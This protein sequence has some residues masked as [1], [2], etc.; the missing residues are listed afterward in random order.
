MRFTHAT[1]KILIHS[2][3]LRQWKFSKLNSLGLHHSHSLTF[4][5]LCSQEPETQQYTDTTAYFFMT[6]NRVRLF[7]MPM[8]LSRVGNTSGYSSIAPGSWGT[9]AVNA[10]YTLITLG[11]AGTVFGTNP[12]CLQG[13]PNKLISNHSHPCRQRLK[14]LCSH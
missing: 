5:V 2:H 6:K 8:G 4:T 7:P 13:K 14:F 9:S 11:C 1:K 3:K 12:K 10:R